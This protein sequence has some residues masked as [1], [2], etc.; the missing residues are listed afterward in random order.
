MAD[1]ES[2]LSASCCGGT[3]KN[4]AADCGCGGAPKGKCGLKTLLFIVVMLAAVGVGAYSFWAKSPATACSPGQ[5]CGSS[6]SCCPST[7]K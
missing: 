5:D 2:E 1:K 3:D 6:G 4:S 7:S